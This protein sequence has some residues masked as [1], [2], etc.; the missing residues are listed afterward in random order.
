[1]LS[2]LE[3]KTALIDY[4]VRVL[5]ERTHA[6]KLFTGYQMNRQSAASVLLLLGLERGKKIDPVSPA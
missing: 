2:I 3:D 1:M 5:H 4:I 6:A